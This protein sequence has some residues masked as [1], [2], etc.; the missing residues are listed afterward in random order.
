MRITYV[1]EVCLKDHAKGAKN[2]I[3]RRTA[4]LLCGMCETRGQLDAGGEGGWSTLYTIV[5]DVYYH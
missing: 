1:N 5:V 3:G 2:N 4:S